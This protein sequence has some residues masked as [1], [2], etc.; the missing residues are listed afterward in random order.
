[1][2]T[3]KDNLNEEIKKYFNILSEDYPSWIDDY[4]NTDEMQ[5]IGKISLNCGTDYS[6]FFNNKYWYSNLDHSIGVALIIWH[7]THDQKQTLAGLFHDIA[8]PVFKHCIDF[9]NHDSEKQ[10]STEERTLDIIKNSKQIINLLKRDN[11]SLENISDYK[12]YPIADN[13]LPKLSADRLEYNFSCGLSFTS[14][15]TLDEIKE[16]YNNL[17][18]VKNEDGI[19]EIAFKDKSVCEIYINHVSKIWPEFISDKDR[20]LMQFLAD[21]CISMCNAGY[22]TIDDLYSLSERETISKILNCDDE[23]LASSFKKFLNA[24][25]VYKSNY[26][27]DNKYCVNVISKKRYV[28]PLVL[29]EKGPF[30]INDISEQSLK[31]INEFLNL[32]NG[33][34][35][36]YFDF[37]FKPYKTK[38]LTK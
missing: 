34:Y 9:M 19:D 36:T 17:I 35:Y 25:K 38:K 28:N 24:S 21:M 30:R 2:N 4:I 22:L 16:T 29:T 12:L 8:T 15:W 14:I 6:K 18:I 10:E 33:G 31:Q 7:F 13:N 3:Y 20:T 11:I 23:Y 26:L 37:D 5:R 27:V 32:P 1:M